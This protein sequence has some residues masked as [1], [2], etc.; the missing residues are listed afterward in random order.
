MSIRYTYYGRENI[1]KM[2]KHSAKHMNQAD[3]LWNTGVQK[4][5]GRSLYL[6]IILITSNI[7]YITISV[8]LYRG[9]K[10]NIVTGYNQISINFK[11]RGNI[12]KKGFPGGSV[13][14][15]LAVSAG[16]MDLDPDLEKIPHAK[17]Q[18]ETHHTT[19]VSYML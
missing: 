3:I 11:C 8:R 13:N 6:N 9:P 7:G 17:E 14:K 16:D 10:K 12:K 1:S 15:N 4:S 2:A 5:S 18:Q 19:V